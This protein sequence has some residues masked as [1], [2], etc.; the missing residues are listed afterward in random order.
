MRYNRVPYSLSPTTMS[1]RSIILIVTLF[2]LIV[3][4]MF[5]FAYLKKAEIK[6]SPIIAEPPVSEP[7]AYP[8]ITRIDATHYYIE[9][10]HTLVGELIMPTPCDLLET[11][12]T[13]MES[14]PEQVVVDF[15]VINTAEMCAQV[16]TPQRFKV[17]FTASPEAVITARFMGR[18]VELNLRPAAPGETPDDFELFIKG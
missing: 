17:D 16:M 9:G 12:A 13:V 11:S 14:F 7:V 6:Q 3:V 8:D 15:T 5:M 4:G 10:T 2:V 18:D 1:Q